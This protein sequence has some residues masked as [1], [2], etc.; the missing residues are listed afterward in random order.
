MTD[1]NFA[2]LSTGE[3]TYLRMSHVLYEPLD[4][5]DMLILVVIEEETTE[6]FEV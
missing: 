3:E 6:V 2:F 4:A 1:W 5:A